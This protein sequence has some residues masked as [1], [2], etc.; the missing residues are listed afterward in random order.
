MTRHSSGLSKNFR[1][2]WTQN[3]TE[4]GSNILFEG[5]FQSHPRGVILAGGTAATLAIITY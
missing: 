4:F 1:Q 5:I 3:A 2:G